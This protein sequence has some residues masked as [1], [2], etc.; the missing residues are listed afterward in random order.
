MAGGVRQDSRELTRALQNLETR[1]ERLERITI[2]PLRLRA[3]DSYSKEA[4]QQIL[5]KL[6]EI[7]NTLR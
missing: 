3:E 2:T 6:N 7:I 5:D 4:Q 1:I